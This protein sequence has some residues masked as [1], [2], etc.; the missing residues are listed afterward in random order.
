[1]ES[2]GTQAFRSVIICP[3]K[4][5]KIHNRGATSEF[6]VEGQKEPFH[7]ILFAINFYQLTGL[8]SIYDSNVNDVE[9]KVKWSFDNKIF[10][11]SKRNETAYF[12][13]FLYRNETMQISPK[14][15]NI[16]AKRKNLLQNFAIS[17]RNERNRFKTS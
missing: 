14:S 7:L 13:N 1:M 10:S 17:K 11:I 3:K 2:K 9:M 5:P 6:Y 12:N 16:E 15:L 8:L 4:S